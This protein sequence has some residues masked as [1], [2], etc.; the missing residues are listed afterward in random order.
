FEP[1]STQ[2][3]VQVQITTANI[4]QDQVTVVLSAPSGVTGNLSV[5]L[6]GASSITLGQ[7]NGVGAG[8][9]NYSFN[10]PSLS[11]GEYTSVTASWTAGEGANASAAVSFDTLGLTRFSTY[12]TPYE[13]QCSGGSATAYIFVNNPQTCTYST[14]TLNS[15]FMSQVGINGTGSSSAH[16]IVKVYNATAV[17][18]SCELPP[19]GVGQGASANTFVAVSSITGAC[20]TVLSAGNLATTPDPNPANASWNCSDQVLL[21]NS[22]DQNNT[23]GGVADY[24]PACSSGFNGTSGHIDH[25]S[26]SQ[27]CTAHSFTDYGN[28]YAIRLR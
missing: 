3:A 26:S 15:S 6:K 2:N 16:G 13:T 10:R 21:I 20:N 5:T 14:T 12:N 17:G 28:Y 22:S 27:S 9:Y 8:T 19:G 24:C 23:T 7:A 11:T 4:T 25:Y 18:Q 1:Q